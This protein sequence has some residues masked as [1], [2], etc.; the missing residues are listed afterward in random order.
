MDFDK[1][2]MELDRLAAMD[3]ERAGPPSP[4]QIIAARKIDPGAWSE[5]ADEHVG[6]CSRHGLL[7]S[8]THFGALYLLRRR[9]SLLQA[10]DL[11]RALD[12]HAA[13]MPDL[14][15]LDARALA[16]RLEKRWWDLCLADRRRHIPKKPVD[17][18]F[19]LYS[20]DGIPEPK[21]E[22]DEDGRIMLTWSE[23]GRTAAL[24]VDLDGRTSLILSSEWAGPTPLD[25]GTWKT[26]AKRL[27]AAATD[28]VHH[29]G[30]CPRQPPRDLARA[31]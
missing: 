30:P 4:R 28:W 16:R 1:C 9:L 25:F 6:W 15:P 22:M 7:N 31:A 21:A 13:G 24:S 8:T 23:R 27:M 3:R 2:R 29:D 17:V 19:L 12:R 26:G 18:V 20:M 10:A 5:A 11:L 14:P